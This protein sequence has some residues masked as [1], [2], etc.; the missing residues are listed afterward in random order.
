MPVELVNG[1]GNRASRSDSGLSGRREL[2][3]RFAALGYRFPVISHVSAAIAFDATLGD[4]AQVMA[5]AVIQPAARIGRNVLVNTRAVV[6]HDC[7]VGDHAHV[8]PGASLLRR[9]VDWRERPYRR[10]RGSSRAR[11]RGSRGCRCRGRRGRKNVG[12]GAF[13]GGDRIGS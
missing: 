2:F 9:R 4:G 5:G 6:E 1:L 11:Q 8:A 13:T 3:G 10:G 12:A 7:V